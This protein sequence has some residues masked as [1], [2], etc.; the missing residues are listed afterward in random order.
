MSS[1]P[2][3][4]EKDSYT[5]SNLQTEFMLM[6]ADGRHLQQLTHFNEPGYPESQPDH[7]IAAVA[8]FFP[9][10]GSQMFATVMGP[11][12]SKT[13]WVIAFDGPCGGAAGHSRHD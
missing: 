3:A 13:N 10:D 7:T 9:E 6:D 4:N 2:Y 1:Y 8:G 11:H 12:F 5:V